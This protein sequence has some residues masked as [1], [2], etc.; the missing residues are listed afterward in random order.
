MDHEVS[1]LRPALGTFVAVEALAD[2]AGCAERGIAAAY[3]AIALVDRLMHP[4]REGSDLVALQ[5]CAPGETL[6]VHAWTWEVLALCRQL[7]R[8]SHG[9]FDPCLPDS[10][11][12]MPDIE[13]TAPQHVTP[14]APLSI[15][16]GGIAKGFAVDRALDALRAAGCSGGLVNAGG[17]LAVFGARTYDIVCRSAPAGVRVGPS[18]SSNPGGGNPDEAD[19]G[20]HPDSGSREPRGVRIALRNAALATSDAGGAGS[21]LADARPP[22]HRGYYDGAVMAI[23]AAGDSRKPRR[24]APISGQ[25]TV[26]APT[27]AIADGLTKCLLVG[28]R[29]WT[30]SLL[31]HYGARRID[32]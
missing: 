4:R 7:N 17:D 18:G 3:E 30:A 26:T 15:D 10:A 9:A 29:P 21:G 28:E 31:E 27:A 20:L 23:G 13:L 16:L 12:R 24:A 32:A 6:P 1:R 14:R 2:D 11:A 22:E 8:D 25:V 19:A 5:R